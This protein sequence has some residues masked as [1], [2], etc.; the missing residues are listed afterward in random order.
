[1]KPFLSTL[2]FLCTISTCS[3]QTETVGTLPV[4]I[5]NTYSLGDEGKAGKWLRGD[6]VLVDEAQYRLSG[7][8]EAGKYKFS[9]TAQRVF[10]LTG[11]LQGV[12][13]KTVIKNNKPAIVLPGKENERLRSQYFAADVVAYY[14]KD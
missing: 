8:D 7:G 9:A 5:Y 14:K 10:F 11:P 3:A 6:V 2:L 13:A 1:M 4:G 12:F